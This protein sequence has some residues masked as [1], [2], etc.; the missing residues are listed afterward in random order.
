MGIQLTPLG[1][2]GQPII[3]KNG[4]FIAIGNTNQIDI[5]DNS[6][7]LV[8]SVSLQGARPYGNYAVSGYP[9]MQRMYI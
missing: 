3:S 1:R 6:I 7:N 4:R 9:M 8:R 2:E 5:Y